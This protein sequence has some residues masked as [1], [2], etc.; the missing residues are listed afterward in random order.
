MRNFLLIIAF[1]VLCSC[2]TFDD[3]KVNLNCEETQLAVPPCLNDVNQLKGYAT[4]DDNI[5]LK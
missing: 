3:Q 4:K 5:Y 1:G 2:D